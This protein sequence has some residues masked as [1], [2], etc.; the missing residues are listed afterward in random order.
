[1]GKP[2]KELRGHKDWEG[3][4]HV[5]CSVPDHTYSVRGGWIWPGWADRMASLLAKGADRLLYF[6][7][8]CW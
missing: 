5:K 4:V 8:V 6:P 2:G 1:M 7:K 3:R